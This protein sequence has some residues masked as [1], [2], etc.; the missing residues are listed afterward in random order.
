[1]TDPIYSNPILQEA[2]QKISDIVD[3]LPEV[4]KFNMLYWVQY[5]RDVEETKHDAEL[6][7]DRKKIQDQSILDYAKIKG[8]KKAEAHINQL[9]ALATLNQQDAVSQLALLYAHWRDFPDIVVKEDD[10][11]SD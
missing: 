8:R 4:L 9:I 2:A 11:A 7:A 10:N 5:L 6:A 3:S 1:M